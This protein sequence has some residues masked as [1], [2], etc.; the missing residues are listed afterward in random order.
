MINPY[1]PPTSD[2]QR[3][4]FHRRLWN[5]CK[6]AAA[7]FRRGM[8][9]DRMGPFTVLRL[10]LGLLIVFAFVGGILVAIA[11]S[12]WRSLSPLS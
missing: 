10:L 4:P 9:K 3:R 1:Q 5:A 12:L 6:R 2:W 8:I 11:I 7:E